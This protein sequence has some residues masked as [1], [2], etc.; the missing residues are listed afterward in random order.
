MAAAKVGMA[1]LTV[2][3]LVTKYGTHSIDLAVYRLVQACPTAD[4]P[5]GL[6]GLLGEMMAD[7][8]TALCTH[9]AQKGGR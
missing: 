1:V 5:E 8:T 3:D 7:L 9:V 6:A 2:D 4:F